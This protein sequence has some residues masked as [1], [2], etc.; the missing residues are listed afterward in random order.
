MSYAHLRSFTA[1]AVEG[2]FTAAA[3][4]LNI[5]QP[6]VTSQVKALEAR[7]GLALFRRRGR[8]V[9]LTEVGKALFEI[10][11]RWMSL[12][13]DAVDLLNAAG[14]L[15][16]GH[17]RVG[18]VGPFHATEMLTAFSGRYPGLKVS[19]TMGNSEEV[20]HGLAEFRTDV[21]VLAHVK[22]DPR[23]VAIPYSR[24][25][26][27]AF[28]NRDHPWAGRGA[29]RIEDLQGQRMVLREVGSTTRRAF[30]EA[31]AAAG[32]TVEVVMEIGSRE[33][34]WMA[35]QRG[36]GIGVVSAFEFVAHPHLQ[37]LPISNA[38]IH[39]YAHVVYLAERQDSRMIRAFLDVVTE[40]LDQQTRAG[41]DG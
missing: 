12:E 4:A 20:L 25:P 39:T 29:I 7:Y 14:G 31:L 11:R 38:E 24:H 32:V 17:L 35:V 34:V 33:A 30:E 18:A 21:G 16:T 1:V 22:D 36:I 6:T 28:V 10:T 13:S 5:G 41:R 23:F 37:P 9:E 15:H 27:I 40:I 2:G 26:V 8:R 3:R 19:V